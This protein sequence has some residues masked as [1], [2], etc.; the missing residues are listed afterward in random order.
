[1]FEQL[2]TA[3]APGPFALLDMIS[4]NLPLPAGF[5]ARSRAALRPVLQRFTHLRE[6]QQLYEQAADLTGLEFVAAIL[7]RLQITVEYDAA[8][9]RRVPAS[10]AF[11][12]VANHPSGM[13]DGLVL[14]HVLGQARPELRTVANELLA[15]LLPQLHQQFVLV[16]PD[17]T[18]G[19][20][21]VPGLRRLLQFLHNDVPLLLFP[22]GEV[23]HRPAPFRR[24]EESAWH[25]TAGRLIQ[26]A[27]LPVLPVWVSGKNSTSFNWL[28]LVH[29]LLRTARLPV[30]LLNKRGQTVQVRIGAAVAPAELHQL[31]AAEQMPYLRARVH[32]LSPLEVRSKTE[33]FVAPLLQAPAAAPVPVIGETPAELLEADLAALRPA[34]KLV[35]TRQWEVYVAKKSEVPH[36]LR[37]IGRLREL[38]FRREGEGTLQATDLDQFDDYY[39]HLFLYDRAARKLVAAY[40]IGPGRAIL[41]QHGRRGF[42]LNSLFRLRRGLKPLLRQ[43]L[44]LGRAFVREEYQRQP[45]P[46]ALLWKGIAAYLDAHPE[47]RYLIGPVSI[48]NR[49]SPASKAAMLEYVTRHC[50]D[51]ELAA[52]VRPRKRYRYRPLDA[53]EQPGVLQAGVDSLEALNRLVA[54]IEPRGL[55]IPTLLRQYVRLNARFIGF[56]LDPAFCNSLDGFIV[57]DARELP[58]RTHRLLDRVQGKG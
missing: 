32:A 10:G 7:E 13:L 44:E 29:P 17:A 9:L 36:V 46:L 30:E 51:A 41:R 39:R 57:L 43:S 2:P 28:G 21:N 1:M 38:T 56:N 40:R 18:D 25:P 4:A 5:G 47:Y 26:A 8:E 15:P 54:S 55:G 31:P 23:A 53:H 42:Y 52:Q 58:E 35:Q 50:F 24:V 45:L 16:R 19:P 49:F 14:L 6:L 20:R 11:I 12:A 3:A 48:S 34:R 22:A 37:E 33:R 27:R